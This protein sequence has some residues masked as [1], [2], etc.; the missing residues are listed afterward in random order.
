MPRSV[1]GYVKKDMTGETRVARF[2]PSRTDDLCPE[3]LTI[4]GQQRVWTCLGIDTV[5]EHGWPGQAKWGCE[6]WGGAN[7]FWCL[8]QDLEAC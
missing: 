1:Y 5:G 8:H 2:M 6:D 3:A 7:G 4:L